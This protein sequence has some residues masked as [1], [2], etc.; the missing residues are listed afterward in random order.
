MFL[1]FDLQIPFVYL[2]MKML[3]MEIPQEENQNQ[4]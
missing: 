3:G 4:G 1:L 2:H